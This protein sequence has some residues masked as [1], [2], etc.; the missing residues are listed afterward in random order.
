MLA[1][2]QGH[3]SSQLLSHTP[4]DIHE[5][6]GQLFLCG[7]EGKALPAGLQEAL[8]A[9][10]CG[11]TILFARNI[12][13]PQEVV[14]LNAATAATQTTIPPWISVDQE[15]GRV[16]RL[17]APF[18][19]LPPAAVLGLEEREEIALGY[20]R[21]LGEEAA[22]AGFNL[23]F[24]PI[25]DVHTN[26][27]NPVIGDRALSSKAEVVARLA[28]AKAQG[29][30]S[31]GVMPCGKHFPGHGDTDQDSHYTLPTI[32]H[33]RER[34]EKVE[35]VPFR[36]A[37]ESD[38]PAIMTAHVLFPALDP[39]VPATLSPRI[40]KG[41]LREEW[42]YDGLVISDDLEMKGVADHYA[43]GDI[44]VRGL[45]AGID[46]FLLCRV[47][48]ALEPATKAVMDALQDGSLTE[49]RLL[50][51]WKRIMKAKARFT[52]FEKRLRPE[53]IDTYLVGQSQHHQEAARLQKR[54]SEREA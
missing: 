19:E 26:P 13:T 39:E 14:A 25:L 48:E 23:V 18:T 21:I 24:A 17:R 44:V 37:V 11:G 33:P 43:I 28:L 54:W 8:E 46:L 40:L 51:S 49:E 9:G 12:G 53:E 32:S 10:R 20:G 5:L 16:R 15:G 45:R 30:I 47:W 35:W 6:I 3:V 41:I 36:A 29:L 2:E 52:S 50:A 31:A 7:F 42:G 4:R 1:M 22:A 38:I 27:A 34:L